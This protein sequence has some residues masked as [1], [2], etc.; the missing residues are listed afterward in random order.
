MQGEKKSNSFKLILITILITIVL[1]ISF[2][3][4]GKVELD[5]LIW[6]IE[7]PLVLLL[8]INTLCVVIITFVLTK[9]KR[10]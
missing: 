7:T 4:L 1:I 8:T 9:W 6:K 3:N 5:V 10:K 2:Q